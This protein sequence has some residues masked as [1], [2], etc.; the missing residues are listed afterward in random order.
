[1]RSPDRPLA[2]DNPLFSRVKVTGFASARPWLRP[3]RLLLEDLPSFKKRAFPDGELG[4][5]IQVLELVPNVTEL[6]SEV[7]LQKREGRRLP[8]IDILFV[9]FDTDM[10]PS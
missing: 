7:C 6:G 4:P 10:S 5:A 1:M 3:I 2:G 8:E 9:A